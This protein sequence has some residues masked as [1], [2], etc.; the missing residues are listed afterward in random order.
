V[1]GS[2]SITVAALKACACWRRTTR[3]D[4]TGCQLIRLTDEDDQ[5]I[6][7]LKSSSG[8]ANTTTENLSGD[9]VRQSLCAPAAE[10][11]E[12]ALAALRL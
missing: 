2:E 4:E 5:A 9:L 12:P 11:D 3:P 8:E 6:G 1:L 7:E 10:T